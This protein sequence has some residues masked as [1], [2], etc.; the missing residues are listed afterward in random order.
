MS[1]ECE[2]CDSP[3]ATTLH[4]GGRSCK[5]C[6]AFFRRTV[7]MNMGYKCINGGLTICRIHHELRMLCRQCR[8][9]KCLRAGMNK[10]LVQSRRDDHQPIL[11]P[12]DKRVARR[13]RYSSS[14]TSNTQVTSPDS[15]EQPSTSQSPEVIQHPISVSS[16]EYDDIS[17]SVIAHHRRVEASL[18]DRRRLMYT[19][20][21]MRDVFNYICECPYELIH[22]RPFDYRAF[23]GFDRAD[24]I[25]IYDYARALGGFE[26]LT[27]D[28][29]SVFYRFSCAVDCMINSAYYT[30]RLGAEDSFLILFNGEFLPMNPLPFSGEEDGA[31]KMFQSSQDFELYKSLMPIKLL[32]W[33]YMALP[34]IELN[35]S[36]EEFS[37]LK[38]LTIWQ[39]SY[40]KLTSNGRKICA[41]QR[42]SILCALHRLCLDRGED[43]AERMGSIILSMNYIVE[44]VQ[45]LVNSYV[46]ITFFDIMKCD[47]KIVDCL[48]VSYAMS[49]SK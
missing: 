22:L 28:E 12:M 6:A 32:Q 2:V 3:T 5:A 31:E 39:I 36:F 16:F 46:M 7:S 43:P 48:D 44:Q 30:S 45:V 26:D 13:Q 9:L 18:N 8:F 49:S 20:V 33:K 41:E 34:F 35:V 42:N 19:E 29:K 24:F 40:Y 15:S 1:F 37:L 21:K 11:E 27:I 10:N 23:R 25:M 14:V 17:S 4:F 47:S 38:V